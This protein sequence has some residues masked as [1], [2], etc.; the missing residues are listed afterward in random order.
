[1]SEEKLRRLNGRLVT[2]VVLGVVTVAGLLVG[3][4]AL[5]TGAL[6]QSIMAGVLG[7]IA[8]I[9][10]GAVVWLT[11]RHNQNEQTLARSA[12]WNAALAN[13]A[14]AIGELSSVSPMRDQNQAVD[15]D[16]FRRAVVAAAPHIAY[17]FCS[18][19]ESPECHVTVKQLFSSNDRMA[20]RTLV[21]TAERQVVLPPE[22]VDW[23]DTNTD[24]ARILQGTKDPYYY[25]NDLYAELSN[26]YRNSHFNDGLLERATSADDLPYAATMVW[27]IRTSVEKDAQG[28][29]TWRTLGFLCVD[30]PKSHVFDRRLDAPIGAV[31]ANALYLVWP[32]ERT[33]E[34]E[35]R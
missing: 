10:V 11:N 19:T 32:A 4:A 28:R 6:P 30:S 7:G 29:P 35:H 8:V 12:R 33:R 27:P 26:G 22:H 31:L 25:S 15:A 14:K 3:G 18:V 34:G 2:D 17:A 21:S 23:V 9:S 1:M 16:A 13:I 24:F 20:V 5:F